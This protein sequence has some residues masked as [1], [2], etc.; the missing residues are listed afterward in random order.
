VPRASK[1]AGPLLRWAICRR[2]PNARHGSGHTASA[3]D[4]PA[5]T[6]RGGGGFSSARGMAEANRSS[7][8]ST[9][10]I[11]DGA[12]VGTPGRPFPSRAILRFPALFP[13]LRRRRSWSRVELP[14]VLR[15]P[16]DQPG[17][18]SGAT[19]ER[20]RRDDARV[21]PRGHPAV[22]RGERRAATSACRTSA[23]TGA[24]FKDR[25][26]LADIR[27]CPGAAPSLD[28]RKISADRLPLV[29]NAL[30][31]LGAGQ[32]PRDSADAPVTLACQQTFSRSRFS[33]AAAAVK[34]RWQ[35]PRSPSIRP[36]NFVVSTRPNR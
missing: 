19:R 34:A 12:T 20:S 11:T 35:A 21:P 31:V 8:P 13:E 33:R 3:A 22:K 5:T 23:A 16:A 2:I 15:L 14:R 10:R 9:A 36:S 4:R 17:Q 28:C 25:E 24:V 1:L 7:V 29:A 27:H 6:C 18:R 30:S 26:K 32:R